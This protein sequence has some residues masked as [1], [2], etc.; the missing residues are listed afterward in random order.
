MLD[1]AMDMVNA[2]GLTVSLDHIGFED[3]IREAGVARSAVYRRWPYKDL[4]FSDLLKELASAAVP[5]AVADE[6]SRRVTARTVLERLDGLGTAEGRAGLLAELIR[7]AALGD[8]EIIGGSPEWS[9]YLALN[10]AFAGLPAGG[11]R[12]QVQEA[13]AASE[14]RFVVHLA[15]AYEHLAGLLGYRLRPGSDVTFEVL[16]TLAQGTMRGLVVMAQSR[17]EIGTRRV[18]AA[19]FGDG[20]GEWSLPA[21]GIAA[22]VSSFLEPDPDVVWDAE[23]IADV[24]RQLEADPFGPVRPEGGLW[25]EPPGA[26]GPSGTRPPGRAGT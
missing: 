23:R 20:A 24:R 21:L 10:A 19:P 25:G 1:A 13:L 18:R 8:F 26:G 9:T 4:F 6:A 12:D 15:A 3:V 7:K 14:R 17:P 11:L 16:A 22:A 2:T 5:A